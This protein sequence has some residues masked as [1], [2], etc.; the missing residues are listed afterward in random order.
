VTKYRSDAGCEIGFL[1]RAEL[2]AELQQYRQEAD[3]QA[4]AAM[5]GIKYMRIPRL[6]GTPANGTVRL[7]EALAGQTQTGPNE[8]GP[9]EGYLWSVRYL[10]C[11][12]LTTG[13][14]PDLLNIYR[15]GVM[16]GQAPWWQLNGNNFAVTFG[17][18]EMVLLGGEKLVAASLG[19]MTATSQVSLYGDVIE[20]PAEMIG[21]LVL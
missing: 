15:N 1:T 18:A 16:G 17:R 12:G 5:R 11:N 8:V 14:S 19:S 6:Y 13:T 4:Q 3:A 20:V 10:G 7:G 21:K 2:H 9:K